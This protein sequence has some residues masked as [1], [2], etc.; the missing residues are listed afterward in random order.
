MNASSER[1]REDKPAI[2]RA[3]QPDKQGGESLWLTHK[4]ERG[5]WSEKMLRAL[6]RGVKGGKWFSLIDKVYAERTLSLAWEKVQ[7]NAGA[8]GV[9][10]ITIVRFSKDS[11]ERLLTVSEHLKNGSYQPKP[12]K[13]VWI[14]KP[15][16][17]QTRALGIPTVTD[18]VVQQ[19]LRMVLE[20]IY[21]RRFTA[22]SYG[23]RPE[24]S[25]RDALRRVDGQLADGYTHVVD[26]DIQG[27]FDAIDQERLMSLLKEDV[28]DGPLLEII[29]RFLKAG[30]LEDGEWTPSAEGTPQGGVISPLLSNL[31][32]DELDHLMESEGYAMTRYADDMVVLC[33][34]SAEASRA[35]SRVREWM[36]QVKLT[37]H[38]EKTHIV[39]MGKAEAHFDFL[40]YRFMRSGRGRIVRLVRP[41]SKQKLRESIRRH[42][43]RCNRDSMQAITERINRILRGWFGYYKHA[44]KQEHQKLDAWIRMRL[45]SIYRKR[46]RK[47]GR[48]RGSDHQRWPNRHFTELGLF[49]LEAARCEA[50]S[51][52]NGVKH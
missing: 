37:L 21:E 20:P 10:G 17:E 45:R 50:I 16:S 34:S 51:L 9:D 4:A 14:P 13:R 24:R 29:E 49:S 15:G 19:A 33:Q 42:T 27:Y 40:G 28:S 1:R 7:S 18:R 25:C 38:P 44:Y 8:C 41:K 12:V 52:R 48:G 30:V 32:L 46:Y 26:I 36:D 3:H 47:R 31:Y 39:D 23:F 22:H 5:V 11:Q 6:V 35:L 43:K 2:V